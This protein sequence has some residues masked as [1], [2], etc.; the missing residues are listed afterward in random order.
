VNIRLLRRLQAH[1]DSFLWPEA[2]ARDLGIPLARL[3]RDLG[4]L[5]SFGFGID[6]APHQGVRYTAP[7]PSLCPDQ[8]EWELGTQTIGRRIAYWRRTTSTNDLAARAARTPSNDGLVVLAEEQTAGRGRHRRRWHA[9]PHS[10]ILMSVLVFPPASLRNTP[11]LTCLGAVAVADVVIET[12]RL[13]ARIKWPNDVRVAGQK[14]CGILVEDLARSRQRKKTDAGVSAMVRATVVGI[15]V[16]VNIAPHEFPAD[17]TAPATSLMA[18]TGTRLDRSDLVRS[19]VQRLDRYYSAAL[20]HELAP[21][22]N[23]WRELAD[24]V[25]DHVRIRLRD[26]ELVGRLVDVC[27]DRGIYVQTETEPVR[28]LTPSEVLS[29]TD[30][31]GRIDGAATHDCV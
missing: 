12:L 27:P 2:L 18:L 13:P 5:E 25:G 10:S 15:G 6:S 28:E 14:I 3:A 4:E 20:A 11:L 8:I 19:L 23:R 26:G 9:P 22:W 31:Q 16:N 29:I 1:A 24:L 7:A 17:L 30:R 21:I